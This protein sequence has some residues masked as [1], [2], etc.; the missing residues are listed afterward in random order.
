MKKYLLT[1]ALIGL[2][3]S[4]SSQNAGTVFPVYVDISPDTLINYTLVPYSNETYGINLFGDASDDI[5]I[6]ANG[7]V[8]SGGTAG[9]IN[10]RPLNPDVLIRFGRLDS[11]YVPAYSL[12]YV[13]K[14]AKPLNAGDPIDPPGA[15]W[16]TMQYITDHSGYGGGNKNVNDWIGGDKYIGLKYQNGSTTAYGW[17]RVQCP[18]EDSCY[19]KD[20]SAMPSTVS[21]NEQSMYNVLIYPNPV[22]TGFYLK[23]ISTNTFDRSKLKL[24]DMYGK[25]LKFKT[26]VMIGEIRIDLDETLPEGCY[27]L[28]YISK[29]CIFSKKIIKVSR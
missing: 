28:E 7:A 8:S 21:I 23:N 3:L 22:N 6:K 25:E 18:V 27:M 10:V 19:V 1:T 5:E 2:C 9:Y 17:I 13:T 14:V 15:M 11:V 26:E 16:D 24:T 12:W 20:Y 29:D 4:A